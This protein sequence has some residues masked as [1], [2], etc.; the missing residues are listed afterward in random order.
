MTTLLESPTQNA[1]PKRMLIDVGNGSVS[2]FAALYDGLAPLVHAV[3][4]RL[5]S[6]PAIAERATETVFVNVWHR[7]A[8]YEL[9]KQEAV[10]WILA[11]AYQ[12]VAKFSS[13]R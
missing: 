13:H 6:D 11:L 2:A 10:Q 3:S 8:R 5:L 4:S 12:S 7:A 1:D 9:D